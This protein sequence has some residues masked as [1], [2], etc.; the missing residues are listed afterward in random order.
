MNSTER[1]EM[2][3]QR[4]R[5]KREEKRIQRDKAC[6]SVDNVFGIRSLHES[7]LKCEKTVAYKARVQN[8]ALKAFRREYHTRK[9]ILSGQPIVSQA[10]REIK[11][12]ERGRERKIT[13]VDIEERVP[14]RCLCDN[15]LIPI[16][17]PTLI[18]N[19]GASLKGRGVDFARRRLIVNIVDAVRKYG[20]NCGI[21]IGDFSKYF[22]NIEYEPLFQR[23][24]K[25][26]IDDAKRKL[27]DY[28]VCRKIAYKKSCVEPTT[29]GLDL[30]AQP[31]QINAV[32]YPNEIDHLMCDLGIYYGRYMDDTYYIHPSEEYLKKVFDILLS[33]CQKYGI[34]VNKKK[35]KISTLK[36]GFTF[37]KIRYHTT[38]TGKIIKKPVHRS[39]VSE[40]S[41]IRAFRRLVDEEKITFDN[42]LNAFKSWNGNL[43]KYTNSYTTRKSMYELFYTLFK[44][45]LQKGCYTIRL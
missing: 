40:R 36:K 29:K 21:M 42:A 34:I 1:H 15:I 12:V 32:S 26:I 9:R 19:N 11:I 14:Q 23:N 43:R 41:K 13:P 16:I 6:G 38:E 7:F 17:R 30:G 2:R 44:K 33:A 8:Y 18:Y 39:V 5:A 37:L 3:Y 35:T 31:S 22:E 27:A 25:Y 10:L 24:K 45:E 20:V 28:F 4:R